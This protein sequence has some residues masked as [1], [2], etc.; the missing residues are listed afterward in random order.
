[1]AEVEV[2]TALVEVVA[3]VDHHRRETMIPIAG[4]IESET[5]S[6]DRRKIPLRKN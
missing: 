5:S 4:P 3:G 2:S 6:R 1:V